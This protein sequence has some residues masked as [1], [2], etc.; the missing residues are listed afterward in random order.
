[1]Q[2]AAI[3]LTLEYFE[4][5]LCYGLVLVRSVFQFYAIHFGEFLLEK[6]DCRFQHHSLYKLTSVIIYSMLCLLTVMN[7]YNF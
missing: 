7:D 6:F 1:M 5:S 2:N 4:D 3:I